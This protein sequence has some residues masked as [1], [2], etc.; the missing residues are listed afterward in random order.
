MP[1]ESEQLGWRL[2]R[3]R[4]A[5]SSALEKI[6]CGVGLAAAVLAGVAGCRIGGAHGERTE[7]DPRVRRIYDRTTG[8]L[9]IV[10]FDADGDLRFDSWAHV[11]GNRMLRLD[12][13]V[14]GNGTVDRREHFDVNQQL[15]RT[16]YLA[17]DGTITGTEFR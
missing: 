2:P 13:D 3:R 15:E 10:A 17:P 1:N 6:V 4:A 14:D 8:V 12:A 9:K 16:D 11:D 5:G 7:F